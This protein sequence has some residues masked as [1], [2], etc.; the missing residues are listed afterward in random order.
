MRIIGRRPDGFHELSSVVAAVDLCDRLTVRDRPEGGIALT[1]NRPGIPN[2]AR[3]LVVKAVAALARRHRIDPAIHFE[4][5]KAIPAG[6]GLGGGSSDAAA[7]ILMAAEHWRLTPDNG[8]LTEVAADVGSDVPFF[9]TCGTSVMTGRGEHIEP[10]TWQPAGSVLLIMPSF[11]IS[12]ADVYRAWRPEDAHTDVD[13]QW[14]TH[15]PETA[16]ALGACCYNDLAPAAQRVCPPLGELR[17]TLAGLDIGPVHLSGSGSAMF[18]LADT[19][20]QAEDW[21]HCVG[22]VADVQTHVASYFG[23]R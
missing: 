3:N 10:L 17:R 14:W 12:T 5:H 16:D 21:A 15:A 23:R 7:A 19:R 4:L 1:C 11:E 8:Q 22:N 18:A 2:D 9:L 13:H 6:A 20:R